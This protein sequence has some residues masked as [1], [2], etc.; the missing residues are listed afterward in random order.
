MTAPSPQPPTADF[1]SDDARW[2]ALLRRDAR[3]ERIF[4]VGVTSTRIYCRPTYRARRP[5]RRNVKF[6]ADYQEAEA[7]GFRPCKLCRPRDVMHPAR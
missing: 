5:Q 4:L 7:L 6:F 3:A 1:T 2:E